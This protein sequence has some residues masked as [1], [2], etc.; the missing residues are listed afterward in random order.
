[1]LTTGLGIVSCQ[2]KGSKDPICGRSATGW[3]FRGPKGPVDLWSGTGGVSWGVSVS[4]PCGREGN[5]ACWPVG[6]VSAGTAGK[7]NGV[8]TPE[9]KGRKADPTMGVVL[10]KQGSGPIGGH[11]FFQ[12]G[13]PSETTVPAAAAGIKLVVVPSQGA[14]RKAI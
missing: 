12:G 13:S 11:D 1:M 5:G 4:I 8:S 14:G 9:V 6:F 7:L 2:V 10:S 3:I